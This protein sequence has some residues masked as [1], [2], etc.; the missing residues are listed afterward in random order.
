MLC[1]AKPPRLT[2][3]LF[4]AVATLACEDDLVEPDQQSIPEEILSLPPGIHPVISLPGLDDVRAGTSFVLRVHLYAVDVADGVASYQGEFRF[5]PD[6]MEVT[7]GH[8]PDGVLGA[9]HQTGPGVVRFAGATM[10]EIGDRPAVELI[11]TA[12]RGLKSQDFAVTL[13]EVVGTEG[14]RGLMDQVAPG[15]PILTDAILDLSG[16]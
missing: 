1:A 13:E 9:W 6:A 16:R 11:A 3:L 4:L 12:K 2:L 8:F 5:D 15:A 14:F 7:G 10:E